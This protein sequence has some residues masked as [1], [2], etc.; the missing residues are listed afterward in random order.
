MSQNTVHGRSFVLRDCVQTCQRRETPLDALDETPSMIQKRSLP[1]G[2]TSVHCGLAWPLITCRS[3]S[4][5][6]A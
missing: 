6:R 2:A 4:S 3:S 5:W 1:D